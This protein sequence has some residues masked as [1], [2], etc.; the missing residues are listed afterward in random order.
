MTPPP[1]REPGWLQDH[2]HRIF[3]FIAGTYYQVRVVGSKVPVQGPVLLVSNHPNSLLDPALM[4]VAAGRS[5]RYLAGAH[6]F[7]RRV[8]GW[9]VRGAGAIPVFRREEE[10]EQMGRNQETFRAV[11]EALLEG[12]AVG[13]FPEGF[14]H[15]GPHLAPLKT[16]AARMA[17]QTAQASDGEAFPII[18][19]GITYRGGK[20]RFRT[21]A[22]L[23]V[24]QPVRWGDLARDPEN[25]AHVR[26]LT[27]R[28]EAALGRLTVNLRDWDDLPLVELA[29]SIHDAELGRDRNPNP[30]RWLAR[31]RRTAQAM[32]QL[33][34]EGSETQEW[35]DL[36][37]SLKNHGRILQI[38]GL[39]PRDLHL[40]PRGS[41]AIRW[42]L[43][44]LLFFGVT[45]PL[46]ALGS[47]IFWAPWKLVRAS[48]PRFRLPLDR[49]ATYRVLGAVAAGGGWV[50]FLATLAL[51][52]QG[53]RSA[54]SVLLLFPL[55]GLLTLR[56]RTRWRAAVADLRRF[57][58]LRGQD[59]VRNEL[60]ETQGRL[61]RTIRAIQLRL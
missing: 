21:E 51:E 42:T 53:W 58:F 30:V 6:L 52:F 16:G 19:L 23:W 12:A 46:A 22:I 36:A 2:L 26:I 34:I 45:L 14:T 39:T 15:S 13:V 3:V 49:Q 18:P 27:Q 4:A 5:V 20:E 31:M 38:L 29:E 25:P 43:A 44:N 32:D 33:R 1:W 60:L 54:M 55:I 47:L 40:R 35:T 28:I 50:L 37:E 48:E 61:A 59:A 57:L 24:G 11:Q 7:K 41:V 10:P 17:L 9:V 56:I 8:M